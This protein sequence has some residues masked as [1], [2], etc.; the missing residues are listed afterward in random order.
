MQSKRIYR[1]THRNKRYIHIWRLAIFAAANIGANDV[2][3]QWSRECRDC[4]PLITAFIDIYCISLSYFYHFFIFF[5]REQW[6]NKSG[7]MSGKNGSTLTNRWVDDPSLLSRHPWPSL[8]KYINFFVQTI[9]SSLTYPVSWTRITRCF[10]W[11]NA[12]K[13]DIIHNMGEYLIS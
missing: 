11:R 12:R 6:P 13:F 10:I 7:T 3:P 5:F 2:S 8:R 4:L 9:H 1:V